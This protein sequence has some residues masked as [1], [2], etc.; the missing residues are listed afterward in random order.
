MEKDKKY[1]VIIVFFIVIVIMTINQNIRLKE[2]I[3]CIQNR[4]SNIE[5]N[6]ESGLRNLRSAILNRM[7]Y[8][9]KKQ[10]NTVSKYTYIYKGVEVKTDTVKTLIEFTLKQSDAKSKVYLNKSTLTNIDGEDY[11]CLHVSGLNYICELELSYK[12]NYNISFY[13]KSN[14]NSFKKL[15]SISY[16]INAKDHFDNRVELQGGGS[17][18]SRE[19]TEYSFSV[20]NK[21]FGEESFK[22][23]N[24]MFRAY[25]EGKEVFEKD[26]TTFNIMNSENRE[27]LN[28]MIAE[29]EVEESEIPEIEYGQVVADKNG[30]ESGNYKVEILHSETG[31]SAE[32]GLPTYNIIVT[33]TF[34]NGDVYEYS[35]D[36]GG[37]LL[38]KN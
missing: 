13:E 22:I 18:T 7:D 27:K 20:D 8:L 31:V 32:Y 3:Q 25:Y 1:Y 21:T 17:S 28:L 2:E 36:K 6:T 24:V 10:Q 37:R 23:K 30:D 4:L 5:G 14:D 19:K 9:L 29:G 34:N 11:E 15:N 35:D 12:D 33:V 38:S 26:V 16:Q